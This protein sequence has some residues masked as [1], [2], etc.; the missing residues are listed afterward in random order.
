M[1]FWAR[2]A[3]RALWHASL[4][5]MHESHHR[6]RDGPFELNDV[7]AIINAVPAISLMAYGF[8]N[9]GLLPG[10]CFGAVILSSL[11]SRPGFSP[12][13]FLLFP[14]PS[15]ADTE[16]PAAKTCRASGSRCS[17][18]PTCSSTT[19]WSTA[20]SP[21]APSPTS[22]TSAGW[23]PPTRYCRPFRFTSHIDDDDDTNRGI[24]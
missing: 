21:W 3:H 10:L 22:L 18:W 19:G 15:P 17:G 6:P 12:S 20:G 24:V 14:S 11:P 8:L 23:P 2:W 4:W 7:F 16:L 13:R 9:R 1:E 5:N